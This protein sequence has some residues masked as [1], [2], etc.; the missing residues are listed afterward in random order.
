MVNDKKISDPDQAS[1][2]FEIGKR[3][4]TGTKGQSRFEI[5]EK[6]KSKSI[7]L[8]PFFYIGFSFFIIIF[9]ILV[10][11]YVN[12]Y[13]LP[14]MQDAV[15]VADVKYTRGDVVKFIRFNQRISEDLGIE[16]EIG[17]SLF[18]ALRVILEAELAYQVAPKYGI[19]VTN[20]QV[21]QRIEFLMGFIGD[22]NSGNSEEYKKNVEESYRQF[23]NKTGLSDQEYKDYVQ[24]TMF[25][26]E[27]KEV[28]SRD[29][30]RIQPQANI[31]ELVFE[32]PDLSVINSI[33]RK[34]TMGADI[35]QIALEYSED[36]EVLRTKGNLGWM[37][38]GI[39]K[40]MD[41]IIFDS[42][43]E[44]N[45]IEYNKLLD[46]PYR[47]TTE[48]TY[49]FYYI[50]DYSEAREIDDKNFEI[51]EDFE[52]E[53]FINSF[54]EEY[55]LWMDIDSDIYNWIN[56]KVLIASNSEFLD[57]QS[58]DNLQNNIQTSQQ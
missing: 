10:F 14:P 26:E 35:E 3:S 47:N 40:E 11:F 29:L 13:V 56:N 58:D 39:D 31:Y 16:F 27:L 42:L 51:L 45:I 25:R 12:S 37:P 5:L 49:S 28:V 46:T 44:N 17:N 34:L 33:D 20:D 30:S 1:T 55:N 38:R 43:D 57:I 7:F 19:T 8:K 50:A 21:D 9:F 32:T 52:F 2:S 23:L 18:E 6:N 54:T 36:K 4:I 41:K 48:K 24:R 22:S 15:R 53:K